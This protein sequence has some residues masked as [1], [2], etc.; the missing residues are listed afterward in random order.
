MSVKPLRAALIIAGTFF[1][2]SM[3][4]L[5]VSSRWAVALSGSLSDLGQIELMKG[6]AFMLVA[7]IGIFALSYFFM[8]RI[9]NQ[10]AQI[11]RTREHLMEMQGRVLAGTL[12]ASVA[13]DLKNLLAVIQP[14]LEFAADE[15]L[16]DQDRRESL[17]DAL[18]ATKGLSS[19]ND[20]LTRVA[21]RGRDEQP[22]PCDIAELTRDAVSMVR[23]HS[24]L[25]AR[26]VKVIAR[27]VVN[28]KVY[29]DLAI[30]A[31]I[32][33]VLN[34]ADAT[35]A[36]GEIQ[37]Y[38]RRRT[39]RVELE[40]HD[41]GAGIPPELR[42]MLLEP[43]ETTKDEGTGLGLFI[44]S[45]FARMH[46]GHV[47]LGESEMGGALVRV[48]LPRDSEV[49]LSESDPIFLPGSSTDTSSAE[50]AAALEAS[51]DRTSERADTIEQRKPPALD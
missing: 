3:L 35:D 5:W 2:A 45:H 32:N 11:L 7:A 28:L 46:G 15:S 40:V 34:A 14:N 21:R 22:E 42:M 41:D 1:G 4:Y 9:Q 27:D 25:N 39:D 31:I 16:S 8:R 6:S 44:V 24:K 17:H 47:E 20:R 38:V 19:L 30:H 49:S 48:T 51:R 23:A 33:L 26:E 13:H 43:F 50:D 12:T 18:L 10:Q 36:G 29:P 37:I